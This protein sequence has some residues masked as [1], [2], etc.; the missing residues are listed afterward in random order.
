MNCFDRL[1]KD[2]K[3]YEVQIPA[4]YSFFWEAQ[5]NN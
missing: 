5:N 1:I 4:L 2:K 3:K